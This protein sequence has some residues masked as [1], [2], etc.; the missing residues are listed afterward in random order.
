MNVMAGFVILLVLVGCF[1]F[2]VANLNMRNRARNNFKI[3]K[4][5]KDIQL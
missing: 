2:V 3:E 4:N 5:Y 1:V